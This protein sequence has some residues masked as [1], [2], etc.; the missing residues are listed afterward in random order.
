MCDG[1]AAPFITVIPSRDRTYVDI[2][3]FVGS[4]GPDFGLSERSCVVQAKVQWKGNHWLRFITLMPRYETNLMVTDFG[5]CHM[6]VAEAKQG[7]GVKSSY[8]LDWPVLHMFTRSP[9]FSWI[10]WQTWGVRL[11]LVDYADS[12]I[13]E[14][15]VEGLIAADEVAVNIAGGI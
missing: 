13:S 2:L 6:L 15:A 14:L 1:Y 7:N 12:G 4:I 11:L 9:G 8:T 5:L 3:C 10:S